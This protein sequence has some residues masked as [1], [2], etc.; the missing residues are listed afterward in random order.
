M[1]MSIH[2]NILAMNANRMFNITNGKQSKAAEKLSSGYR[3]NR[4]ADDAAGLAISEKMRRQIRGLDQTVRNINEG[5]ALCNVADGALNEIS[6]ML[7]REEQ[8]LV[9]A[10]N[11]TNTETDRSYIE[12]ELK[13]LANE[14]D[15]TFDT[16][17]YNER[18][19]FKGQ[20]QILD[21]P[22]P[23]KNDTANTRIERDPK[24]T[25]IEEDI[26]TFST[27]PQNTV[28]TDQTIQ[29]ENKRSSSISGWEISLGTDEKEH[30]RFRSHFEQGITYGP[31]TI[32]DTKV[33]TIYEATSEPDQYKRTVTT[34]TDVSREYTD[35]FHEETYEYIPEYVDIQAGVESGQKIPIRLWNL[36]AETLLCRVPEEI[37]AY[38]AEDSLQY[39]KNTASLIANIRS[40]YGAMTNRLE[41]AARN[42]SNISENTSAA[43][44]RIRDTDMAKE[45]MEYTSANVLSQ[46]GQSMLSQANQRPEGV[47]R[48]LG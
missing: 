5:I 48:L 43:E 28:K 38:Q 7:N 19:I 44:S 41:H 23:I 20:N 25:V 24:K 35:S 37:T 47:L 33:T 17:S 36:S 40:Y 30:E 45:M 26:V 34:E 18:L 32:T 16:A 22:A 21:D 27:P 8:L 15:R 3:I 11:D 39:V 9:Q 4:S 14:M 46:A 10:A 1:N 12:K 42:N 31:K 29:D 13:Q 2:N 6:D